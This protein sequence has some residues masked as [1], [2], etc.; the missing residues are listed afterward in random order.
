LT[1]GRANEPPTSVC[2]DGRNQALPNGTGVQTYARNLAADLRRSGRQTALLLDGRAGKPAAGGLSRYIRAASP[3]GA[4]ASMMATAPAGFDSAWLAHDMYRAAQIHFDVYRR[5]QSVRAHRP[6]GIMHWT[7]PLPLVFEGVP[8]VYTIHDLIPLTHPSLT[9]IDSRRFG[10][11]LR[12][13]VGRA[14]H[15]VTV[16]ESSRRDIMSWLGVPGEKVTTTYQSVTLPP[17]SADEKAAVPCGYFLFC[18]TIEA[19]KNLTRLITAYAAS[20]LAIPLILAG[21]DGRD[22]AQV[23]GSAGVRVQPLGSMQPEGQRGVWRAPWLERPA[24]L[25]LFRHARALLL[26]SL[27][28]GFGLPIV[29]AMLLGVPVLTSR[30]GATGEIAG[31][32]AMLI[33]P[34]DIASMAAA[35]TALDGNAELRAQ[36]VARGFRRAAA[37]TPDRCMARLDAVY[38]TLAAGRQ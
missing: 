14:D 13:V 15:I 20:G 3:L 34:T 1:G 9:G 16:S 28:E 27:A 8:N 22:A 5:L 38:R 32:A 21:P 37:F 11:I 25:N 17:R 19:R 35:M 24:L 12:R 29:E 4:H 7:Y 33:D 2:L 26:P 30:P 6:P 23:L 18:G 10:R 36:Y 31:D